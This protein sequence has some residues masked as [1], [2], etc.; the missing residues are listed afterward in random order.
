MCDFRR[1]FESAKFFHKM[2][3]Q[4]VQVGK[5]TVIEAFLSHFFPYILR[6]IQLRRVGW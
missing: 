2:I 5:Y 1:V 6:W 3:F 4:P